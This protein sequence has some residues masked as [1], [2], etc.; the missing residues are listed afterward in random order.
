MPPIDVIG[1]N[2]ATSSSNETL[3]TTLTDLYVDEESFAPSSGSAGNTG[4]F[5]DVSTELSEEYIAE[6]DYI[7]DADD[8]V[9]EEGYTQT[10][11]FAGPDYVEMPKSRVVA[12]L[13]VLAR[14]RNRKTSS[15][16]V[17]G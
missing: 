10:G 11:A 15:P 13:V 8:S 2:A 17:N 14:R 1:S 9:Y 7:E 6:D 4:T 5:A 16:C 12:F 3:G